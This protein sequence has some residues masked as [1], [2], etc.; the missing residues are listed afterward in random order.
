MRTSKGKKY[1]STEGDL[2]Q[3]PISVKSLQCPHCGALGFVICHGYLLGYS[4]VGDDFVVRGR[5][6]YC[7]NRFLKDGC[8]RTFSVYLSDVLSGFVVR[9]STFW[10]FVSA[11][12]IEGF[13]RKAAWERA[14]PGF[15]IQSGYR[16]WKRFLDC[17]VKI[18]SLLLRERPPPNCSSDDPLVQLIAHLRSVFPD[19]DCCLS[20]F[21]NHFQTSILG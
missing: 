21:Q 14:A 20:G 19:W 15:S 18:R 12:L 8:G 5:R 2:I 10:A 9:A 4:D 1:V 7:S 3:C 6:F 17:Q 16:L 13:S 11:V